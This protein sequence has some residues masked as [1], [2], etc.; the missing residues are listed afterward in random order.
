[1]CV[2]P[3]DI[4]EPQKFQASKAPIFREARSTG[5]TTGRRGT[6]LTG[7]SGVVQQSS[8]QK[9]VLLGQ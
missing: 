7:G 9:K 8:S 4:P 2:S 1:M 5:S 3:P 6:L